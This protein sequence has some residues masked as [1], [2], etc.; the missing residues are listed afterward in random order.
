MDRQRVDTSYIRVGAQLRENTRVDSGG[1][2]VVGSLH[3][4]KHFRALAEVAK[5][6]EHTLLCASDARHLGACCPLSCGAFLGIG[7]AVAAVAQSLRIGPR[8]WGVL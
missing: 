5:P 2:A 3:A 8:R 7:R 6:R 4:V 1:D